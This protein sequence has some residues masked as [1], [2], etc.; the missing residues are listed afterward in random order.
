MNT[1]KDDDFIS[2][3]GSVRI[4]I[5]QET[6]IQLKAAT[7]TNDPVELSAEEAIEISRVLL[8]FSEMI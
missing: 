3:D 7:A 8:K 6:S 2:N 4:W 1:M 5:E